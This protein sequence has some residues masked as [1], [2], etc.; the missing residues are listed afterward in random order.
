M[1]KKCLK[2]YLGREQ[3]FD[4]GFRVQFSISIFSEIGFEKKFSLALL[5]KVLLIKQKACN[6]EIEVLIWMI[7]L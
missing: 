6:K 5:M 7:S 1:T 4:K 2:Y 3:P